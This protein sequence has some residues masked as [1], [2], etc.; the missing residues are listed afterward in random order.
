MPRKLQSRWECKENVKSNFLLGRLQSRW[1]ATKEDAGFCLF[2]V[3][4]D[5][6]FE[7]T[8]K[9]EVLFIMNLINNTLN[10]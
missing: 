3:W 9:I 6:T 2:L 7:Q 8:I 1:L 5:K 10:F 4:Q